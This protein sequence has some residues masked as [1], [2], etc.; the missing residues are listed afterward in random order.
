MIQLIE[1]FYRPDKGQVH[2]EGTPMTELNVSWV[3]SQ[4]SLVAQEPVLYDISV[5]DNIRFGMEDATQA[6]IE[7]VAQEA[8]CHDFVMAFPDG[9]DTIVGSSATSQVS[10]G[11]KQRIAIARALLRNP[12]LL[13]LDEATSALDSE[14]EQ[15]VQ[16]ALDNITSNKN[17]TVVQI[18]HRLSTIRNSDRIIVLNN[19]KVRENGSHDELMALKGHYYRLVKLQSLDDD[20]DRKVHA[21]PLTAAELTDSL[22]VK[23]TKDASKKISS[24]EASTEEEK[25]PEIEKSNMKKARSLAKGD[26]FFFFIGG[27]G[28]ILAGRKFA[29]SVHRRCII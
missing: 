5:R 10:G 12:K 24:E 8:N 17:R 4:M 28:A 2:Y 6:D 23:S 9:Y 21:K 16:A 1:Q 20:D 22:V 29:S 3:R 18:A 13:L 19:G 14:S 7:R 25:N 11:Q 15:V 26:E 27:I